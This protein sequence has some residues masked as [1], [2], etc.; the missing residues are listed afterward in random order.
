MDN[1]GNAQWN[2]NERMPWP[3]EYFEVQPSLRH[4]PIAYI[5]PMFQYGDLRGVTRK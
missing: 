3:K 1:R 5:S 4:S 2:S